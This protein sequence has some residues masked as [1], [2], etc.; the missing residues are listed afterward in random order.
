MLHD[1]PHYRKESSTYYRARSV[2]CWKYHWFCHFWQKMLETVHD[3][4]PVDSWLLHNWST[5]CYITKIPLCFLSLPWLNKF[6]LRYWGI[7]L[8]TITHCA[9]TQW[10]ICY[11]TIQPPTKVSHKN[12]HH[13]WWIKSRIVKVKLVARKEKITT[14]QFD[15]FIPYYKNGPLLGNYYSRFVSDWP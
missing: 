4:F 14:F 11:T 8:V 12:A 9:N 6:F 5:P 1:R 13:L 7:S 15:N 3:A 2:W 10:A